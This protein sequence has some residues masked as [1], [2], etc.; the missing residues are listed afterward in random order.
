MEKTT[1]RYPV[2]DGGRC[3]ERWGKRQMTETKDGHLLQTSHQLLC[4]PATMVCA[5]GRERV[6]GVYVRLRFYKPMKSSFHGAVRFY[7][8]NVMVEVN[9]H[10]Y[11]C[12]VFSQ[13]R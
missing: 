2:S 6:V 13:I 7:N 5:C 8:L 10:M 12:Y 1:E 9:A 3:L 11:L 4:K